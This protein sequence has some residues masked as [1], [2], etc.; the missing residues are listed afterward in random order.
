VDEVRATVHK[1]VRT[2]ANGEEKTAWAADYFD[3][4]KVRHIKTFP[5]KKAAAAWLV[6]TQGEVT[7]GTW[8][9][10][11]FKMVMVSRHKAQQHGQTP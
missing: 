9:K 6:E 3:Q 11:S 1:R 5:T 8:G 7:R 4:Q 2:A 10:R